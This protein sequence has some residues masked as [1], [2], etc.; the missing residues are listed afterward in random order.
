MHGA[1]TLVVVGMRVGEGLEGGVGI[2]PG[3][4]ERGR[5]VEPMQDGVVVRAAV[6]VGEDVEH[7]R[8]AGAE[9]AT[10]NH[11]K[12]KSLAKS[13]TSLWSWRL[14]GWPGTLTGTWN[15]EEW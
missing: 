8:E 12:P 2:P 4:E 1:F 15:R 14:S 7:G 5:G 3:A 13:R 6:T 11:V 10:S 9:P